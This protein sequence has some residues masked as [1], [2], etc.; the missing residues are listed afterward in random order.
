MQ[1]GSPGVRES[2]RKKAAKGGRKRKSK[3]WTLDVEAVAGEVIPQVVERLG[4]DLLGMSEREL[5][6]VIEPII[7]EIAKARKTKPSVESLVKRIVS[8][9]Q[10]LYKALAA[11]LLEREELTLEQLEFIVANA[12]EL[13]GRAAP[14]LY[15]QAKRLGAEY[16][17]DSLRMLWE[18]YGRPTGVVCPYCGFSSVLPDL[19]CIVCGRTVDEEDLKRAIGFRRL[20]ASFSRAYERALVEEAVNAGYVVYDRGELYPPSMKRRGIVLF[21]SREE[22]EL[23]AGKAVGEEAEEG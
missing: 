6:D 2:P 7:D 8:G 18:R 10:L 22:K 12:P 4:L 9:R 20:L 5:R 3:T 13:A 1:R 21:L 23:L 19:S 11:K 14:H 15:R 16:I 17:I